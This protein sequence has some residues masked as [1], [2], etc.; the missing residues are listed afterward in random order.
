MKP[1]PV[2]YDPLTAQRLIPT[3]ARCERCGYRWT[4]YL[5]AG[6]EAVD[7]PRCISRVAFNV[8]ADTVTVKV[9]REW[10][11]DQLDILY[12][13]VGEGR[14]ATYADL[15]D[16]LTFTLM[17]KAPLYF[18]VELLYERLPLKILPT[19]SPITLDDLAVPADL[20]DVDRFNEIWEERDPV[21]MLGMTPLGLQHTGVVT[22]TY[23]DL[24]RMANADRSLYEWH[25]FLRQIAEQLE[26]ANLVPALL[27]FL[28]LPED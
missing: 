24:K 16:A 22:V 7:C 17:V 6:I 10:T 15:A 8:P 27:E 25:T 21:L 26:L 13:I 12:R 14:E 3:E 20:D 28:T 9:L 19:H 11:Q 2:V 5:P 1:Q 23:A 18:W 4:A